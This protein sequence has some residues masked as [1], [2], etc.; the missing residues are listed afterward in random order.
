MTIPPSSFPRSSN[1]SLPRTLQANLITPSFN[2]SFASSLSPDNYGQ[3]DE[4]HIASPL[5]NDVGGSSQ[6]VEPGSHHTDNSRKLSLTFGG[7]SINVSRQYYLGLVKR[8]DDDTT[9]CTQPP[10]HV[11]Y[12]SYN[13]REEDVWSS[14][15][16]IVSK[17]WAYSDNMRLENAS[18]R[19]WMKLKNKLKTISPETLDWHKDYD[20]TWL[21]GPLQA[22]SDEAL[23]MA[24]ISPYGNSHTPG[25]KSSPYKKSNLKK[26][27]LSETILQG[28]ISASSHFRQVAAAV[29]AEQ[30]KE[31]SDTPLMRAATFSHVRF[32]FSLRQMNSTL[33]SILPSWAA[34]N[35]G[36]NKSIQFNEQVQQCI[37]VDIEEDSEEGINPSFANHDDFDSDSDDSDIMAKQSSSQG[38][39]LAIFGNKTATGDS[40]NVD[41]KTIIMLPN[42]NLNSR[43]DI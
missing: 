35:T 42:I 1:S 29:Q 24:N 40:F 22:G 13:W 15:K 27:S 11:D 19:A 12:L 9:L 33:P 4:E 21:Y 26:R 34:L 38:K 8:A 17:R 7:A 28:S 10:I 6:V 16:H 37:A 3:D 18:W 36:E 32:P 30:L 41:S 25:S 14:W 43:E 31:K 20:V 5:Y 23:W 2:H 39:I